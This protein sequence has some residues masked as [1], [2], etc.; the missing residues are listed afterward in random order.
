MKLIA[1]LVLA[2]AL[3]ACT[4]GDTGPDPD[5]AVDAGVNEAD[6]GDLLPFMA[7][8]TSDDQCETGLCFLYNMGGQLC[9]H[10]CT[11]DADCEAPSPG[12]NGMGICK[13]PQ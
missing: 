13:R 9:T 12:C 7:E 11:V 6:A 4:T 8:C 3:S 5:P 2:F 10:A 1:A